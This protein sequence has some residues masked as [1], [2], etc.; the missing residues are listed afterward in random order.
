MNLQKM[1]KIDSYDRIL[2]LHGIT[3]QQWDS[4]VKTW[5]TELDKKN[6]RLKFSDVHFLGASETEGNE[7]G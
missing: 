5:I 7:E 6:D 1:P 3:S 2:L 4:A